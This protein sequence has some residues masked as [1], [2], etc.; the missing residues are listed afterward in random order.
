MADRYVEISEDR[1]TLGDIIQN[2]ASNLQEIVRAEI[3]LARTEL[4]ERGRRMSKAAALFGGGL[5]LLGLAGL[6]LVV[7]IIAALAL[8]MPVWAAALLV[9]VAFGAVGGGMAMV[10]RERIRQTNLRPDETIESVK[11]DVEWLKQ[12][13]R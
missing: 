2:I 13:T 4:T 12:Q 1:R 8:V 5:V 3:R 11:E 10:G 9:A 6:L 7:T